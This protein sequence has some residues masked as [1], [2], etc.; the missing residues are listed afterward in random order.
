MK[1]ARPKGLP[2]TG[3][4]SRAGKPNKVTADLK[5]MILG[6]LEDGGGQAWLV[7]QMSANPAAFL[8]LIGKVLPLQ[9]TGKDGGPLQYQN[10]DAPAKE[11]R[12]EWLARQMP[13]G[14]PG[15]GKAVH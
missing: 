4:G 5:A 15:N 6:A 10:I 1:M 7:K 11:T 13:P 2:K 12:D 14:Q 3:G 9:L 8:T